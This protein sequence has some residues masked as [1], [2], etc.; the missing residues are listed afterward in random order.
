MAEELLSFKGLKSTND[1]ELSYVDSLSCRSQE[2]RRQGG[3]PVRLS[4]RGAGTE[5]PGAGAETRQPG[6][7][8]A[9]PCALRSEKQVNEG[10]PVT[11][12]VWLRGRSGG[13]RQGPWIL[14]EVSQSWKWDKATTMFFHRAQ[15]TRAESR[16][17]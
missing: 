17:N 10:K 7:F 6:A 1:T 2:G 15:G 3:K 12:A 13:A 9:E 11:D 8:S 16:R 5:L 14:S 4:P